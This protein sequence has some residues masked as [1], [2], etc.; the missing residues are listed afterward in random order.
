MISI[1]GNERM[2]LLISYALYVYTVL[3]V[4]TDG[5]RRQGRNGLMSLQFVGCMIDSMND[6]RLAGLP[7]PISSRRREMRGGGQ[8]P[9]DHCARSRTEDNPADIFRTSPR[10]SRGK[11]SS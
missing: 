8:R 5:V 4:L 2:I 10:S 7:S 9:R 1:S 3:R 6:P 11:L